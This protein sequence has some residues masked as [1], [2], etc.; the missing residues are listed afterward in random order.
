MRPFWTFQ[1]FFAAA[2]A[3]VLASSGCGRSGITSLHDGAVGADGP[4]STSGVLGGS[5]GSA[6]SQSSA[7]AVAGGATSAGGSSGTASGG[8]GGFGG[9]ATVGAGGTGGAGG[10]ASG[11]A[12]AT[13]TAG[14]TASGG[15]GGTAGASGTGGAG[16]AGVGGAGRTGGAGG[17]TKVCDFRS[18]AGCKALV[19]EGCGDGINN[20]NGIEQCDDGNVLQGRTQLELSARGGLHAKSRLRRQH[21]WAGRGLRR[22][23]HS[24][25]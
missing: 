14:G 23:Q 11:G 25:Q 3:I 9:T 6:G 1:L 12:G 21:H 20:Q 2:G 10:I 16:T 15:A 4:A 7:G 17:A 22:R 18:T 8:T 5:G 24:R 19:P 13:A